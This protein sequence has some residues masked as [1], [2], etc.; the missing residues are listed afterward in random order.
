M[1]EPT[2]TGSY[3]RYSDA[4]A[5][6]AEGGRVGVVTCLTCGAAVFLSMQ[7]DAMEIHRSWHHLLASDRDGAS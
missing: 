4:T 5:W 6:P 7:A 2:A 1:P 3:A